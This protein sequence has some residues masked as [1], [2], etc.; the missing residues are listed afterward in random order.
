[1]NHIAKSIRPF[2]GAL[3]F[4]ESRRFYNDL[5]FK[6]NMLS[7]DMAYFKVTDA[8]G[9]YLQNYYVADWVNNTMLF[10]E[11]DSVERYWI[12]LQKMELHLRYNSVKL[13]PIKKYDWGSE[14][15]LND[16]AGNL[17]HF[18]QFNL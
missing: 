13:T 16:P 8:L 12:E 7:D 5:Q 3:H 11:V 10:L 17:W 2:L 4:E 14:C 6:E 18:G 1:M 15:F 9:F